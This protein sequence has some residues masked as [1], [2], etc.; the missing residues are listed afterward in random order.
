MTD[1]ATIQHLKCLPVELQGLC[2]GRAE[3]T[4]SQGDTKVQ[5]KCSSL[6]LYQCGHATPLLSS[7]LQ[8]CSFAVRHTVPHI[9]A[10]LLPDTVRLQPLSAA[11][12]PSCTSTAHVG[13]A[14]AAGRALILHLYCQHEKTI[15]QHHLTHCVVSAA[16]QSATP[17]PAA[18]ELQQ[19]VH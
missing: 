3:G 4:I 2:C 6:L 10:V 16:G 12:Q 5:R 18:S 7:H 11:K 14:P 9:L 19:E 17:C 1:R 15:Q 8:A 13:A